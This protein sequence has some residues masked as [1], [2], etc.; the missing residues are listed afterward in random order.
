MVIL[1]SYDLNGYERPS[2]YADVKNMIDKYAI[3]KRKPLYSQWFIETNDSTE[4]W[5]DRMKAV[6]DSNDHWFI[7]RVQKPRQGWL[8]ADTWE[9][10][11]ARE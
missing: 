9:W 5:S 8:P 2:A 6:T 10:L 1:L 3:S 7:I 4:I 11:R